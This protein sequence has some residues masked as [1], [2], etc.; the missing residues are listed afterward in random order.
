MADHR[1]AV[2]TGTSSGIGLAT[3]RALRDGGWHVVGI[4]RREAPIDATGYEHIRA[5]LRDV[6]SL[7]KIV[8]P[9]LTA[10]MRD[11]AWRRVGLVNNAADS[12]LLG[13]V[14]RL[15]LSRLPDVFAVN[16]SAPLWMIGALLRLA[17]REASVRIVNVSSG[18]AVRGVAGLAAY[19]S[20]KA[21]LRMAGMVLAAE[22]DAGVDSDLRGRDVAVLSYEPGTVDTPMQANAREQSA[23]VLPSVGMFVGFK[24]GDQLVPPEAPAREIVAFL[25]RPAA[26]RF[27]ERR[28]GA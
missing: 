28:L 9:R 4:A 26:P 15:D 6:A 14:A 8:E 17:P 16:L 10:A 23:D 7:P 20:S 22:V 5:D 2:V 13:P 25:E 19:G 11:A 21:A 1:L 24:K 27:L 3:A 12:G 18:A